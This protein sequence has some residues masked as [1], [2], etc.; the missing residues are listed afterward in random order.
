MGQQPPGNLAEKV[1]LV[2][3]R[4]RPPEKTQGAVRPGTQAHIM[5]G[6]QVGGTPGL[7]LLPQDPEFNGLVAAD[8]G[9]GGVALEILVRKIIHHQAGK[10]LP[11][12]QVL[13]G[14]VEMRRQDRQVGGYAGVLAQAHMHAPQ[15]Q[16]L[17][18]DKHCRHGAVDAA[19]QGRGHFYT[20]SLGH[21]SKKSKQL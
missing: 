20:F 21:I 19:A 4:I 11:E 1:G 7:D 3:V 8:A 14:N 2:L 16:P 9:V 10:L 17:P 18:A 13:A 12:V 6:G 15:G 5:T